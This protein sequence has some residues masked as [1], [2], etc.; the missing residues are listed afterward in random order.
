MSLNSSEIIQLVGICVSLFTS[1]IAIIISVKTLMQNSK[2][3]ENS[4]RPYIGIYGA[5]VYAHTP[6]YYLVIKNFGQSSAYITSFLCDFDLDECVY[7][8]CPEPFLHIENSTL[9]PGQSFQS[10]IDLKKTLL[11]TTSI[12]FHIC[13]YSGTH[14]YEEDIPLNLKATTTNFIQF[15]STKGKELSIISETLQDIHVHHL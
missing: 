11:K 14:K 10:I 2:M 6:K 9:M 5:G 4:T 13:Y 7:G 8:D 3:M 1:L 15:S 12:N